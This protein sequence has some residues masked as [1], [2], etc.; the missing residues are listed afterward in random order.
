MENKHN[1]RPTNN[2]LLVLQTTFCIRG[3]ACTLFHSEIPKYQY[4]S[5]DGRIKHF[6]LACEIQ[7]LVKSRDNLVSDLRI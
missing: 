6:T 4:M 5:I 1:G 2:L 7:K 3:H